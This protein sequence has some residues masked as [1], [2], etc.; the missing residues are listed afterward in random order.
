MDIGREAQRS[1]WCR[2]IA[3][4]DADLPV[5][6]YPVVTEAFMYLMDQYLTGLDNSPTIKHIVGIYP[7]RPTLEMPGVL[8][9]LAFNTN[10]THYAALVALEKVFAEFYLETSVFPAVRPLHEIA[11]SKPDYAPEA[12]RIEARI[13]GALLYGAQE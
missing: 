1:T 4:P 3:G 8:H 7:R 2:Y 10:R 12:A 6:Q 11:W 5:D 9:F 13:R